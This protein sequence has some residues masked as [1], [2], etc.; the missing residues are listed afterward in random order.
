MVMHC[1][2]IGPASPCD[3]LVLELVLVVVLV[4][5][6]FGL[7]G[8]KGIRSIMILFDRSDGETSAFSSTSTTTS[9]ST[10]GGINGGQARMQCANRGQALSNRGGAQK[11]MIS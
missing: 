11:S 8:E 1:A 10:K 2:R 4:L 7:C 6:V 9:T 5:D 3:Y